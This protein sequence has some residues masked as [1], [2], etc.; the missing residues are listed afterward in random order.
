MHTRQALSCASVRPTSL[1]S[2]RKE[3]PVTSGEGLTFQ[4]GVH[5]WI[6]MDWKKSWSCCCK[7]FRGK[8]GPR[9]PWNIIVFCWSSRKFE[10]RLIPIVARDPFE[11]HT[12]RLCF[13]GWNED[14]TRSSRTHIHQKDK[15]FLQN[16]SN[17]NVTNFAV[18]YPQFPKINDQILHPKGHTKD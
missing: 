15:C 17:T 7:Y 14:D 2:K 13:T 5:T 10:V 11:I 1:A 6:W 16:R 9:F 8:T 4:C 18:T 12:Q 3:W